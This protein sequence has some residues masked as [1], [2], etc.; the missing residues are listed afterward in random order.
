MVSD[1]LSRMQEHDESQRA[2]YVFALKK[3]AVSSILG[4]L[5]PI[6]YVQ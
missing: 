2:E 5:R 1:H 3:A 6:G 4:M